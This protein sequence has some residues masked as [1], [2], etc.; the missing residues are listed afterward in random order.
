[1]VETMAGEESNGEGLAS[2]RRRVVKDGNGRR[3]GTPRC[4]DIQIG[5]MGEARERLQAGTANDSDGDGIWQV[6]MSD[7]VMQTEQARQ[8]ISPLQWL[9]VPA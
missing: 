6:T 9:Y 4:L 5:D 2:G 7:K 8:S 3:G 1:M